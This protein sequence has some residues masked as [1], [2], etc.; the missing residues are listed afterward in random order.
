MQHH[1]LRRMS[2]Y[3]KSEINHRLKT[4]FKFLVARNPLERLLSA[5]IS[6]F[7][8][9]AGIQTGFTQYESYIRRHVHGENSFSNF[10]EYLSNI[11]NISY[12]HK[13]T[14]KELDPKTVDSKFRNDILKR[15]N[16]NHFL[17]EGSRYFNRH[18]VQYSTL[19]HPCHIDYD[20]IVKFETMR[21]DAAYVLSKLGPHHECLEDKYPE[22]F[23][24]TQNT[25]EVFEEYY[26]KLSSE[27]IKRIKK[28]YSIDFKL[29][30]YEKER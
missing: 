23:S 27:Q 25:S 19:C 7:G 3:S 30:D 10:L 15:L 9:Q 1:G 6:K 8:R 5:Y 4:Y 17:P 29:F 20:Y 24:F 16:E 22:L 28:M 26:G 13:F 14:P 11:N 21:E 18:W 12:D 2:N